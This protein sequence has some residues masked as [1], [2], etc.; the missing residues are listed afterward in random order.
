[1]KPRRIDESARLRAELGQA[2]V[3][4][5]V[6]TEERRCPSARWWHRVEALLAGAAA[7]GDLEA[8]EVLTWWRG[9]AP[10]GGGHG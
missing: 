5:G 9:S 10:R 7:G 2:R 3:A 8:V 4:L 6:L 1:M